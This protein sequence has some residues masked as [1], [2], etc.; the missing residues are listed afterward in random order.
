MPVQS[1]YFEE[2][3][4]P[5]GWWEFI[6]AASAKP[7]EIDCC[8]FMCIAFLWKLIQLKFK[9]E[10]LK[11]L[12][13]QDLHQFITKNSWFRQVFAWHFDK[14]KQL[15]IPKFYSDGIE[16]TTIDQWL[17]SLLLHMQIKCER[18][19]AYENLSWPKFSEQ[20]SAS[21]QELPILYLICVN[22]VLEME[23]HSHILLVIKHKTI[24]LL[25]NWGIQNPDDSKISKIWQGIYFHTHL[26][27]QLEHDPMLSQK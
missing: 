10:D 19:E 25:H 21:V 2:V 20:I 14:Q 24:T 1:T 23:T 15:L 16:Q 8:A 27:L 7:N 22:I 17:P 5:P 4:W 6:L 9:Y 26:V 12:T 3:F 13:Q 11:M 18:I